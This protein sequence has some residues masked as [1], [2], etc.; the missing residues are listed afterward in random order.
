MVKL[1]SAFQ[2]L[3]LV[4]VHSVLSL[5]TSQLPKGTEIV[6]CRAGRQTLEAQLNH[7]SN[8][9][10]SSC[11]A[12]CFAHPGRLRR[13]WEVLNYIK[14]Y[15]AEVPKVFNMLISMVSHQG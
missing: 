7:H 14:F 11:R 13:G 1:Y 9:S 3:V 5:R 12:Y 6:S 10:T 4:N 2:Y 15:M 8:Q